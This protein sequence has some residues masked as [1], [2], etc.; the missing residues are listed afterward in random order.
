MFIQT[1]KDDTN[2]YSTNHFQFDSAGEFSLPK[3]WETGFVVW[4]WQLCDDSGS[5]CE[6][7]YKPGDEH[8]VLWVNG[9]ANGSSTAEPLTWVPNV[10]LV[11][12]PGSDGAASLALATA[13]AMV[14]AL[15]F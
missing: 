11:G 13:A 6:P 4:S 9:V 5:G 10:T 3:D 1:G 15:V 2:Q 7:Y 14:A 12:Q 8:H